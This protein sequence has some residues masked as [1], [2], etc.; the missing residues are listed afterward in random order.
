[1]IVE[2]L[3]ILAAAWLLFQIGYVALWL[4]WLAKPTPKFQIVKKEDL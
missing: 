1:M 2:I 4:V 3:L